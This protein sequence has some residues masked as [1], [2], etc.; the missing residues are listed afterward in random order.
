MSS[1]FDRAFVDLLQ[2]EGG[3]S[4]DKHDPGGRTNWGITEEVARSCG[5]NGDMRQ[6]TQEKAREI[7]RDRYW[8]YWF[9]DMPY[10]VAF[11]LFDTS[12]NSGTGQAA[13]ILQ[14]TLGVAIDGH[15][16][17]VT[18]AAAKAVTP[19]VL[20]VRYNAARLEFFASL[21]NWDH[22]GRGWALRIVNNL[23]KGVD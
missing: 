20:F 19:M 14:R 15:V 5:Y 23:R 11:T 18:I 10:L 7:Y 2:N 21:P 16:G 1:H 17:P 6:L 13:R 4:D 8:S 9:D 22:F 3:F 12:V